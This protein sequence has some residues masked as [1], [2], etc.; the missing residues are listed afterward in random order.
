MTTIVLVLN[1]LI[2]L[3]LGWGAFYQLSFALAG[4]FYRPVKDIPTPDGK[5]PGAYFNI[6]VFIPAY[7]EDAVIMHTA[8]A[9]LKQQYPHD[10]FSVE[11]IADQLQAETIE[12]LRQLP[13]GVTVVQFE[14]STKSK[15]LNVALKA[16][17]SGNGNLPAA[18]SHT[19]PDIAVI[20]DADNVMASDFLQ[21]VN[22][23][24][25]QGVRVLQGQRAAKNHQTGMAL[26]D[27]ASESANNHILCRGHRV[28]GLSARLA[29][30]GMAF[31][32]AFFKKAM[33]GIDVVGGFDK[34][35]E[36]YC[37]QNRVKV[38]YD[39]LAVVYD[40]KVSA[41]AS[42]ARQRSRWIA[43]QFDF[44]KQ[45]LPKSIPALL[46][47]NVDFFNK[48]IQMALP[49]RLLLPGLLFI[50]MVINGLAGSVWVWG[51]AAAF[52]ANVL[53]YALALPG[54]VFAYKNLHLWLQI[55]VAFWATI[56][57]M[58]GMKEARKKF[59]VTPKTVIH[60]NPEQPI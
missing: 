1:L 46:R 16:G 60:T 3:Y 59:I 35:L 38:E 51:W 30:S 24:F 10:H 26:L 13:V 27:A 56:R 5:V 50:G 9:A 11:V 4:I 57:A 43:A 20:L 22:Y 48:S 21:R 39:E 2:L 17:D 33:E 45:N 40:E 32:Y 25:H 28:L 36:L 31:D 15:A 41:S 34:A 19:S 47:G 54:F 42:F 18:G 12:T 29:G 49:P 7:R 55:P 6:K 58:M 23:H 52:L 14:K 8:A 37:T 53:S 44:A